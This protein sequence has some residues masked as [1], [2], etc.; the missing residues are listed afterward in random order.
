M[1]MSKP[2]VYPRSQV[3]RVTGVYYTS[4]TFPDAVKLF[5]R[6]VAP[7]PLLPAVREN[8]LCAISSST[9]C[10]PTS[11]LSADLRGVQCRFPGVLSCISLIK[12]EVLCEFICFLAMHGFPSSNCLF[13]CL[14]Q[15]SLVSFENRFVEDLCRFWILCPRSFIL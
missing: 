6:V 15:L 7:F 4:S 9:L 8:S 11:L 13:L 5:S 14:A 1:A 3:L 2:Q 12:R 10:P